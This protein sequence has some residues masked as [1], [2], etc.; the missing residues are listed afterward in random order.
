MTPNIGI[1]DKDRTAVV[2]ILNALLADEFLLY[3]KTRNYHWHV[4]GLQFNDLHRFFQEQYEALD[5]VVD[6]VAERVRTLGGRALGTLTEL[7]QHARLKERPGERPDARAMLADLLAEL[8]A[9]VRQ[10]RTDQEA[11]LRRGDAGT[12]DFLVGLMEK[13]EKTA[14]MLRAFL[15]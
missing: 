7:V 13:H 10:L 4:T 11:A 15:T 8:E 9:L 12:N 14:W 2:E 3:T 5:E 1:S 6:E